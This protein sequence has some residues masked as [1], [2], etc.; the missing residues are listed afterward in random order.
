M[1][2]AE[3]DKASHNPNFSRKRKLTKRKKRKE[4]LINIYFQLKNSKTSKRARR[5]MIL[6]NYK[7]IEALKTLTL[8]IFH[9]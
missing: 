3:K 1:K 8:S 4:E 9:S 6:K 7:Q 2:T 5:L